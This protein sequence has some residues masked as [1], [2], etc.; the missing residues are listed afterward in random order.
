MSRQRSSRDVLW[1]GKLQGRVERVD[2]FATPPHSQ[3]VDKRDGKTA[4]LG[5]VGLV[6]DCLTQ[7]EELASGKRF[8]EEVREVLV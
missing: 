1:L 3:S 5:L 8:G 7:F 6:H 2:S 4:E